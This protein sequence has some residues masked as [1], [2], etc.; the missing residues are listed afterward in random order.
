MWERK[1]SAG[2]WAAPSARRYNWVSAH[3]RDVGD[4]RGRGAATGRGHPGLLSLPTSNKPALLQPQDIRT[5]HLG[6]FLE[7]FHGECHRG[8]VARLTTG[9]LASR[10]YD[11][12]P[13]RSNTRAAGKSPGGTFATAWQKKADNSGISHWNPSG[14]HP[15]PAAGSRTRLDTCTRSRRAIITLESEAESEKVSFIT[16]ACDLPPRDPTLTS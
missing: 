3:V 9:A 2:G 13:I 15:Q 6:W 14:H 1:P 5:K 8:I 16:V 12:L 7:T 10:F 4:L 11:R